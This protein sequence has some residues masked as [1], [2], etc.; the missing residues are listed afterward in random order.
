MISLAAPL[1]SQSSAKITSGIA[2]QARAGDESIPVDEDGE[3]VSVKTFSLGAETEEEIIV[4]IT[5]LFDTNHPLHDIEQ[6]H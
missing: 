5:Q 6:Q 2:V 1:K 4:F 3:F